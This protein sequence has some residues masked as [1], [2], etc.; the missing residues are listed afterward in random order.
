MV[1]AS[2][3]R[4]LAG[5]ASL[6]V[7]AFAS[8]G[9]ESFGA[10]PADD[11]GSDGGAPSGSDADPAPPL[12]TSCQAILARDGTLRG[13]SGAY[14]IAS[15]AGG[16]LP[17]FCEMTLDGGGWTL[18]GRSGAEVPGTPPPFGWSSATGRPDDPK[19]PYSLNVMAVHLAFTEV[20]VATLD[21][22][23][24][25]KFPL[26]SAALYPHTT[27]A[28]PTGTIVYVTG[29]CKP[30][31]GPSMLAFAGATSL[32]DGFF[33]RDIAGLDQHRGLKP[34]RFDLSYQDCDRGGFLD[35]VPG[36]I[37]VR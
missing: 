33:L 8:V 10:A 15:P 13:R 3:A 32:T 5:L 25:Y 11:A 12:V 14:A 35:G 6:A 31:D 26:S 17:V 23:R 36:A 27:D 34:D 7:L 24:A 2:R 20:L 18:A 37:F 9:C 1:R 22:A 16:P 29:D 30:D 21:G 19:L 4:T 28:T